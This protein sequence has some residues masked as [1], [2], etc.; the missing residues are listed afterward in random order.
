MAMDIPPPKDLM[1]QQAASLP[2]K[3]DQ[4]ELDRDAK[5]IG[6]ATHIAALQERSRALIT[7]MRLR[8]YKHVEEVA[9]SLSMEHLDQLQAEYERNPNPMRRR[10]LED[11]MERW[12]NQVNRILTQHNG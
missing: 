9:K 1:R 2:S 8:G 3:R 12:M 4:K 11:A 6:R 10:Y 7:D 5:Q